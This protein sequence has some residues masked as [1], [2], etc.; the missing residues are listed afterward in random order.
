[1]EFFKEENEME[2]LSNLVWRHLGLN[3]FLNEKQFRNN[4]DKRGRSQING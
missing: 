4:G 2:L 3:N 1:M